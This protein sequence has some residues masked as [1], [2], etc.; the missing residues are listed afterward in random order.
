MCKFKD[1]TTKS[2][3][4]LSTPLTKIAALISFFLGTM[5]SYFCCA[6][7]YEVTKRNIDSEDFLMVTMEHVPYG[8]VTDTGQDTGIWFEI[9]NEILLESNIDKR[10]DI[11]PTKR[12]LR[13]INTNKKICTL[14]ADKRV[15]TD[16][17]ELLEPIGQS[18]TAGVLPR[19]G[20]KLVEYDDLKG[21]TIAV[22]LGINFSDVFDV[23]KTIKKMRPP[24][25]L[26]AIKMFAI[27]RVD[28][29]GGAISVLKQ[30]ARQQGLS[31]EQFDEPFIFQDGD[32]YLMCSRHIKSTV[33]GKL[34]M[35]LIR[36]KEKG[37]IR[38]IIN[39]YFSTSIR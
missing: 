38:K 5:F 4:Q 12:L 10:N 23:D 36:L 25:Y 22:P 11:V 26:N 9:L 34:R 28:A 3:G 19:K 16:N 39:K 37:V 18:L 29:V 15:G 33:R 17:F 32:V 1:K 20:I 8:Y 27:G 35:A 2:Y 13:Y 7:N 24:Q 30:I 21:I 31:A 6:E 14:L